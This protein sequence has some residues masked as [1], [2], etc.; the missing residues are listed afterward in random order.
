MKDIDCST[1][2]IGMAELII[3][4]QDMYSTLY[5]IAFKLS[6]FWSTNLTCP[7]HPSYYLF[8]VPL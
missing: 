5:V 3:Q 4:S 1:N 7:P 8:I 6:V 2:Y